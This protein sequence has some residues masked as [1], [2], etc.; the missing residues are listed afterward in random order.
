MFETIPAAAPDPILGLQATFK[1]D[2]RANKV[3]LAIGVYCD[4][5]GRTLSLKAVVEAEKRLLE[6]HPGHGYLPIEGLAEYG[7]AVREMLFGAGHPLVKDGRA[8]TAQCPG[9]TGALRVAGDLLGEHRKGAT[10]WISDPTWP[11]HFGIFQAAGLATKT[12]RYFDAASNSLNLA[13]M[14]EDLKDL[15]AGDAVLLHGCCHNPTG[16][17]PTAAQWKQ[18]AEAVKAAGALPIVD[19][20]YQGFGD[21]LEQDAA[22]LR[23]IL[24]ICPEVIVCSSFSKNF[25]L[26]GERA[27]AMTLVAQTKEVADTAL[28]QIRMAVRRNYSNPPA[29]GAR[30]VAAVLGDPALKAMWEAELKQMCGRIAGVRKAL[31]QA[32]DTRGVQLH[33]DG[34]GFIETQKGMFTMSGLTK[35]RVE[36]LQK[37][38]GIFVVGSGRINVAGITDA[39]LEPVADAIAAVTK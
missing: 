6:K 2:P 36:R 18:I 31:R 15:K 34:N 14:L 39:V 4:G 24:G 3:N 20:A 25:G 17:D 33:K 30:V 11:N 29:H 38:H 32:L 16:V 5:Q 7:A 1:A 35:A 12:Y 37:E 22:G 28:T 13:G 10:V 27:G 26:Y 21:G 9:G 23:V 19:F 8:V